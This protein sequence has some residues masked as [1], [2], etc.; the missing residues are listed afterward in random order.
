MIFISLVCLGLAGCNRQKLVDEALAEKAEV[1]LRVDCQEEAEVCDKY[2]WQKVTI[3]K[4]LKNKSGFTFPKRLEVAHYNWERGVPIGISTIYLERYNPYRSDIWRLVSG[5]ATEGVSH[6][7]RP[8][9]Q[10]IVTED[11]PKTRR[12][13]HIGAQEPEGL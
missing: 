1:I 10:D 3:L 12:I 9:H 6:S 7:E 8:R 11:W 2:C 5:G 13:I 4:I